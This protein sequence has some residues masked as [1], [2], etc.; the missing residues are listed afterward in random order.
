MAGVYRN[1]RENDGGSEVA[2]ATF[3]PLPLRKML[4]ARVLSFRLT[5]CISRFPLIV[6]L[7]AEG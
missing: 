2:V 7:W 6:K 3:D 5:V 4:P 1:N